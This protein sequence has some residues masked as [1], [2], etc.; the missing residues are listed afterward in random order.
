MLLDAINGINEKY[1]K[2]GNAS[3]VIY[4][5]YHSINMFIKNDS[6]RYN[7]ESIKHYQGLTLSDIEYDKNKCRS[8]LLNSWS[9][10]Q[11]LN[12]EQKK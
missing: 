1:R 3:K 6:E 2:E 9:T 7:L 8:L 12:Y 4:N 10:E 11:I 5:Q